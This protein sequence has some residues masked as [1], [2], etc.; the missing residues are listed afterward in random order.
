MKCSLS[1]EV[2]GFYNSVFLMHI[3]ASLNVEL[4]IALLL[5]VLVLLKK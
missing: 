2:C 4:V 5:R 1:A 3:F